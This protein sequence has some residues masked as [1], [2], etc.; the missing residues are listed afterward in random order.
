[1]KFVNG[2][3]F[4]MAIGVGAVL[5]NQNETYTMGKEIEL[6]IHKNQLF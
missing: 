2:Y 1:V 3:L 5:F 6:S 4:P